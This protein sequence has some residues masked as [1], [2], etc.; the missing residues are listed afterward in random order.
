MPPDHRPDLQ[1]LPLRQTAPDFSTE[2]TRPDPIGVEG[3]LEDGGGTAQ[4]RRRGATGG[5]GRLLD[6][7][8]REL[9]P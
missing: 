5:L 2:E 7:R 1:A 4:Q 9:A 3:L 8:R 6:L